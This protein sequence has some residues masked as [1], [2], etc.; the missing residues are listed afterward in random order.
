MVDNWFVILCVIV[1]IQI[2]L[3]RSWRRNQHHREARHAY[4]QKIAQRYAW[5]YHRY[6]THT[7]K[8]QFS[9]KTPEGM[10]WALEAIQRKKRSPS[11]YWLTRHLKLKQGIV[12]IGP[13]PKRLPALLDFNNDFIQKALQASLGAELAQTLIGAKEVDVGSPD[14]R[15]HYLIIAQDIE[16]AQRILS[17]AVETQLLGWIQDDPPRQLLPSLVLTI[18]KLEVRVNTLLDEQPEKMHRMVTL[19]LA[20]AETL[21]NNSDFMDYDVTLE[22]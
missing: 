5:Q 20:A 17:E 13:R 1:A 9:G 15:K 11:T 18:Q 14:L 7:V 3:W 8:Y 16:I 10:V 22:A 6:P 2:I 19:G 21:A 4:L 12:M